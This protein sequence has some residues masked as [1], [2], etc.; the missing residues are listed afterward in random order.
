M[1]RGHRR[2]VNPV[3]GTPTGRSQ[4]RTSRDALPAPTTSTAYAWLS[5]SRSGAGNHALSWLLA[6]LRVQRLGTSDGERREAVETMLRFFDSAGRHYEEVARIR[7]SERPPAPPPPDASLR[8]VADVMARWRQTH[9]QWQRVVTDLGGDAVLARRLADSYGRALTGLRRLISGAPRVNVVIVAAPGRDDDQFISNASA[10]AR[11]YYGQ[12]RGGD[13]VVVREGVDSLDALLGAVEDAAPERLVG[14]VDIFAHGTIE[15]SNQLKLAGR[16]HT[17]DQVEAAMNARSL[18]SAY[19]QSAS[20]FDA[21]SAIEFHGCRLGGGEGQRFLGAAGRAFGG[22]RGQETAGYDQR[23]FPRRYQ[24]DWRGH[25]VLD[26]GADIYDATSL[27]VRRGSGSPA[28]RE[29]DKRVF[30]AQFERHAIRWFDTVVSGSREVETFLAPDE[31]LVGTRL[32]APRKIQVMRSMYDANGAWLLGF[33]HPAHSVPDLDPQAA[34]GRDAYT[35][36]RERQ[37]W[38]SHVLRVRTAPPVP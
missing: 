16:W 9:D 30:I 33:L 21:R 34:V 19:V 1:E 22:E 20:R 4:R 38:E 17:A 6:D 28:R 32:P 14:R 15:P 8:E 24:L 31:R 13:V 12:S 35:F 3:T 37:A 18:T 2:E 23:W 11:T 36:T 10:Y 26:T 29:A 7:E 27:P 25:P 5:Y